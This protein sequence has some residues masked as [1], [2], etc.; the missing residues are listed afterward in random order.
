MIKIFYRNSFLNTL[1]IYI[2][3]HNSAIYS[4]YNFICVGIRIRINKKFILWWSHKK[5]LT[6]ISSCQECPQEFIMTSWKTEGWVSQPGPFPNR[7]LLFF[8]SFFFFKI[9]IQISHLM[10]TEWEIN[11]QIFQVIVIRH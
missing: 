1:S 10:L 6:V 2:H 9:N 8:F 4:L 5:T 7:F 3:I 11:W